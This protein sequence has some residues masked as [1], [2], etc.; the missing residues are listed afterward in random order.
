MDP[1]FASVRSSKAPVM[2]P[3]VVRLVTMLDQG[4]SV[5]QVYSEMKK[6][7]LVRGFQVSNEHHRKQ[8][9]LLHGIECSHRPHHV[10]SS[11]E[12]T[13]RSTLCLS[14]QNIVFP[15][16]C[17]IERKAAVSRMTRRRLASIDSYLVSRQVFIP[18]LAPY[19]TLP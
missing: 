3:D 6:R 14:A 10:D 7:S 9:A 15:I 17:A 8:I 12:Y 11:A 19:A 13:H 2:E 18:P 4:A 5:S 1:S 16:C